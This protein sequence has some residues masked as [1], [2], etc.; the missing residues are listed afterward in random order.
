MATNPGR[1]NIKMLTVMV[2]SVAGTNGKLKA[3]LN[4]LTID[5]FH[6]RSKEAKDLFC[7]I[8]LN[9]VSSRDTVLTN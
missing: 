9:Y 1:I 5:S 4:L 6:S 2:P 8:P 7:Q 3:V